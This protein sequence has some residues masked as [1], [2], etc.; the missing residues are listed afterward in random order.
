M[1]KTFKIRHIPLKGQSS[2]VWKGKEPKTVNEIFDF[3][4]G[5]EIILHN[6]FNYGDARDFDDIYHGRKD[7]ILEEEYPEEDLEQ[8][9]ETR[10]IK[11]F[12]DHII[13]EWSLN[14][15]TF[16]SVIKRCNEHSRPY[17]SWFEI[18]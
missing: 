9:P 17:D 11:T 13:Y 7:W 18:E 1:S 6:F 10:H 3:I 4:F 2:V 8:F 12:K 15:K 14:E 16:E 5:N